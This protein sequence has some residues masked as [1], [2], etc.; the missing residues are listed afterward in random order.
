MKNGGKEDGACGS[1]ERGREG[2]REGTVT[3]KRRIAP[4]PFR[5]GPERSY[6]ALLSF[7]TL[8]KNHSRR[9]ATTTEKYQMTPPGKGTFPM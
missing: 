2:K 4:A 5:F 3:K 6:F 1:A 9:M 7:S 8:A